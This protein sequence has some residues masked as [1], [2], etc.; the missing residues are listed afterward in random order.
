MNDKSAEWYASHAGKFTGSE[1]F[2]LMKSG[3]AKDK[4]FSDT[5]ISYIYDKIA[6]IMTNGLS[7]KYKQFDS[8]ATEWGLEQEPQAKKCYMDFTGDKVTEAEFFQLNDF[9]G[10]TP[11]GLIGKDGVLEIKSPY[12][13]INHIRH[14]LCN[15]AEDL[16]AVSDAYYW[17]I[18]AEL[19]ATGRKWCDFV[20]YDPRCTERTCLKIIRVERDEEI[21]NQLRER[22]ELA[23]TEMMR[24]IE[25]INQPQ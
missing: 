7:I 4:I 15:S 18:M 23:T 2:K 5:A 22:I 11:D 10:A 25:Q 9:F 8:K 14:L 21:M 24:I 3:R 20:S 13:S 17:Q 6:E 12:N 1:I 19:L 16:L